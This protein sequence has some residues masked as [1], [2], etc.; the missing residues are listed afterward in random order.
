VARSSVKGFNAE[1][2]KMSPWSLWTLNLR[3]MTS[4]MADVAPRLRQLR[5]EIKE[6]LLLSELD[7]H[8]NPADLARALITPKPSVTFMVKRMEAVGYVRRELQRD[9]LRRFRLTLTPS[10]R[11]AMESAR[12]IFDEEF[13]RRL[14]R[15]T[16]AQQLELMRIFERMA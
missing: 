8:P 4:L 12:E 16:Q 1:M 14:S 15:L 11:S 13:G 6:F 7:E 9:D 10:G 3:V 5:L 2:R